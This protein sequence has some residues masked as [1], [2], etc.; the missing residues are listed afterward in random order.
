MSLYFPLVCTF[1]MYIIHICILMCAGVRGRERDCS[2]QNAKLSCPVNI[3]SS[4]LYSLSYAAEQGGIR[5]VSL[6][7][8]HLSALPIILQLELSNRQLLHRAMKYCQHFHV[9]PTHKLHWF[10]FDIQAPYP[11]VHMFYTDSFSRG[12]WSCGLCASLS[13]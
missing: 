8:I 12:F 7:L 11:G 1:S 4:L 13:L 6:F 5:K 9:C 3:S 2:C 10:Q